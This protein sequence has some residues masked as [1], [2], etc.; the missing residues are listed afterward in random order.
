NVAGLSPLT[1]YYFKV[2]ATNA[3]GTSDFSST[4]TATTLEAGDPPSAPTGLSSVWT[5]QTS[6]LLRWNGV[7]DA[8][9]FW[10]YLSDMEN[11][12]YGKFAIVKDPEITVDGFPPQATYYFKVSAKNSFGESA[13]SS[14]LSVTSKPCE[15][16]VISLTASATEVYP[17]ESVYILW[18]V[19][20][21]VKIKTS[22]AW[23][24]ITEMQGFIKSAP[25]YQDSKFILEAINGCETIVQKTVDV[26][27][28]KN[29]QW[30]PYHF[31]AKGEIVLYNGGT[32]RCRQSHLS[33]PV[34]KPSTTRFLW[35]KAG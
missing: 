18:N 4:V 15:P 34:L 30:V 24:G 29:K 33:L 17:G 28:V 8:D 19:T 14:P 25:L 35:S 6:V 27:V 5:S 2:N 32:Y 11:E 23:D 21:A 9:S 22:G 13:L 16:P 1:T 7:A 31:Y 20:G 26:K 10:V 12:G 3:F